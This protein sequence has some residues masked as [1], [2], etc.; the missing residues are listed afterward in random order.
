MKFPKKPYEIYPEDQTK[1]MLNNIQ[2]S[3]S[4]PGNPDKATLRKYF[5]AA[6]ANQDNILTETEV[7]N[8]A[9]TNG[10]TELNYTFKCQAGGKDYDDKPDSMLLWEF[11][12]A[13][14]ELY[15]E[16]IF[17]KNEINNANK[18]KVL[19]NV[20]LSGASITKA[21]AWL[22]NDEEVALMALMTMNIDEYDYLGDEL[23]KNDAFLLKA[24]SFKYDIFEGLPEIKKN[25]PE[26]LKKAIKENGMALTFS[27][28]Y[29]NDPEMIGL[30]AEQNF[31]AAKHLSGISA[32]LKAKC[33]NISYQLT[34]LDISTPERFDTKTA[35]E[36]I[37]NRNKIADPEGMN[38]IVKDDLIKLCDTDEDVSALWDELAAKNYLIKNDKDEYVANTEQLDK[39]TDPSVQLELSEQFADKK[40]AVYNVLK[41][42]VALFV[43]PTKDHNNGFTQT[44]IKAL[45]K[46][47]YRVIYYDA[48]YDIDLYKDIKEAGEY[49]QLTSSNSGPYSVNIGGHGLVGKDGSYE[50][51]FGVSKEDEYL[52]QNEIY[53]L[54]L[55]DAGEI[56]SQGLDQYIGKSILTFDMCNGGDC[57]EEANC[58]A[59]MMKKIFPDAT[60]Y[61]MKEASIIR[62]HTFDENGKIIGLNNPLYEEY[63]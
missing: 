32:D 48:N 10:K 1:I 19:A 55:S 53:F 59:G 39:I 27:E 6:D 23:K 17:T 50:L 26:F 51:S 29:K 12:Q 11:M 56:K 9:E 4:I 28:K 60:V 61:A 54:D 33:G 63:K 47:G 25:D 42:N 14:G 15:K 24:I 46:Q 34:C 40:A 43:Y 36:M 62:E 52:N 38:V 16:Q 2:P 41:K 49:I 31:N 57:G 18:E 44:S 30:A 3:R 58:I 21:D 7:Q 8:A 22:K 5:K 45:M 20:A 37:R 35:K 13:T